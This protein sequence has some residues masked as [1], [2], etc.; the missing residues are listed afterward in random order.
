VIARHAGHD[1]MI[2]EPDV[3]IA[4]IRDVLAATRR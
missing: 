2:D 1:I 4:A 3:T